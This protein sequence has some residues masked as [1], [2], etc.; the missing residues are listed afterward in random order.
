LV[1]QGR[2]RQQPD[3]GVGAWAA[4]L[5]AAAKGEWAAHASPC[6]KW[7]PGIQPNHPCPTHKAKLAAPPNQLH[8][9]MHPERAGDRHPDSAASLQAQDNGV[10]CLLVGDLGKLPVSSSSGVQV[11]FDA[12]IYVPSAAGAGSLQ[13]PSWDTQ[14]VT[15]D[16]LEVSHTCPV[17]GHSAPAS[18]GPVAP[19]AQPATDDQPS[20]AEGTGEYRGCPSACTIPCACHQC[21]AAMF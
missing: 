9:C 20:E 8:P 18:P 11:L 12:C 19:P 3:R 10:L 16:V 14:A 15:V 17:R 13:I 21:L 2:L 6:L 1:G 7:T 4:R 5:V